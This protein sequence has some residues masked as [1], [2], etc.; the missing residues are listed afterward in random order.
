M[1][2]P[3]CGQ[4]TSLRLPG[5]A[6]WLLAYRTPCQHC[7]ALCTLPWSVRLSALVAGF[8]AGIAVAAAGMSLVFVFISH[9]S[10]AGLLALCMFVILVWGLAS[11]AAIALV[12]FRFGT[13]IKV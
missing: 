2:C 7:H 4:S 1:K 8:V 13:L 12:C 9:L 3:Y 5:V 11:K 6:S 10:L